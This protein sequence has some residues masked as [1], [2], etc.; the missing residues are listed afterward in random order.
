MLRACPRD[1]RELLGT[2]GLPSV[3]TAVLFQ[4]PSPG[5]DRDFW[6]WMLG[7]LAIRYFFSIFSG[8]DFDNLTE[9]NLAQ[10][11]IGRG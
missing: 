7:T 3:P 10:T 4:V 1:Y 6:I 9:K 2:S 8:A 11:L 5:P